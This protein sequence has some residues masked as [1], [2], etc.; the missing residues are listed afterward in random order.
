M[1]TVKRS[2]DNY[3]TKDTTQCHNT[4]IMSSW[5]INYDNKFAALQCP[6][7]F[8]DKSKSSTFGMCS[9][10]IF[11]PWTCG[12]KSNPSRNIYSYVA[13]WLV[14]RNANLF[15]FFLNYFSWHWLNPQKKLSSLML[16]INIFMSWNIW[17]DT[18]TFLPHL[19]CRHPRIHKLALARH[20]SPSCPSN[21]HLLPSSQPLHTD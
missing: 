7:Q 8:Q 11:S 5:F 10:K 21:I 20:S 2:S 17:D 18:L 19:V 6:Q 12:Q 15:C 9:K 4:R 1:T 14:C 3:S 13:R 16:Y